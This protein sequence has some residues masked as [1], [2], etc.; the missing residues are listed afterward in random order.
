MKISELL[1][2]RSKIFSRYLRLPIANCQFKI[3]NRQSSIVNHFTLIELL[4]VIAIIAI[5]ASMLLPALNNAK[6]ISRSSVC[7]GILKQLGLA[8]AMYQSDYNAWNVPVSYNDS[9]GSTLQRWGWIVGPYIGITTD[10]E[11]YWKESLLC[12]SSSDAVHIADTSSPPRFRYDRIWG[13]NGGMTSGTSAF[14]ASGANRYIGFKDTQVINPSKKFM[15][16]DA[17]TGMT[18]PSCADPGKWRLYG[19]S[20]VDTSST[21]RPCYRHRDRLNVSFYDGHVE[22][23]GIPEVYQQTSNWGNQP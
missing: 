18:D 10:K 13:S 1:I 11:T 17:R 19:D 15:F 7:M 3:V 23:R 5:L 20:L 9:T 6:G 2:S 21:D 22:N 16:M 12:P 4:V 14:V 8:N